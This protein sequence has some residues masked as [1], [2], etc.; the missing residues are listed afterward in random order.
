MK[1][2]YWRFLVPL[3]LQIA[4][5]ASVAAIPF[6]ILLT[7]KTVV[8]KT[9]ALDPYDLLR[10]YSQVLS[11]DFSLVDNLKNLPGGKEVLQNNNKFY[12]VFVAPEVEN[13]V[14]P[15]PWTPVK[16]TGSL[17]QEL[18]PNQI[19]IKGRLK[20]D[21]TVSYGIEEIYIPEDRR[22]QLNDDLAEAN[23]KEEGAVEVKVGRSG[24]AIL[25]SLWISGDKYEF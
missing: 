7:G 20:N 8:F 18:P 25:T 3:V 16:I 22:R 12:V 17:P 10:G 14:P 24:Q 23:R 15:Q 19:A 1:V 2:S 4:I 6:S 21:F 11:Y 13:T 9:I 5:V